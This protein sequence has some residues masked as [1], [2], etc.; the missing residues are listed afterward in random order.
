MSKK[1]YIVE[2]EA[3]VALELKRTIIK[4]GYIF[5]G[6]ASNF[7]AALKG[8]KETM[9]NLILM[10]ITLRH[11]KSGIE[12]AKEIQKNLSIPIIFLTSITDE[13]TMHD[14]I[15]LEPVGYLLKPFRREELQ[16]TILLGLY[17]ASQQVIPKTNLLPLAHG[18]YYNKEEMLLFYGKKHIPLGKKETKLFHTLVLANG[19]AVSYDILEDHIWEGAI[20]SES[21]F[22]TLLYR[23]NLKLDYKLIESLPSYGCR[24]LF[25]QT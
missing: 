13:T 6:M 10:D 25:T 11:S 23:L 5:S 24:L 19:E 4:L 3:I 18:Y 17:K 22:R 2:D 16:S 20:I 9:P 7:D 15:T 21:A 8:I 1:I 14:A 12:I